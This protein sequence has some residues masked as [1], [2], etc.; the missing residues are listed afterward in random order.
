[1]FSVATFR[2][3]GQGIAPKCPTFFSCKPLAAIEK[4]EMMSEKSDNKKE[5]SELIKLYYELY[6]P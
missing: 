5:N 6:E 3:G 1:L 2:F 4:Q